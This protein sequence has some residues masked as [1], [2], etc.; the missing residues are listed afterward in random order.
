M[1]FWFYFLKLHQKHVLKHWLQTVTHFL[2]V[3]FSKYSFVICREQLKSYCNLVELLIHY[4]IFGLQTATTTGTYRTDK[5]TGAVLEGF[6]IDG[7]LRKL[8]FILILI[9]G[10]QRKLSFILILINGL[11]RKLSFILF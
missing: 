5:Y 7:V 8:F 11:Q 4:L 3:F 1:N 10:L 6:V 9:D 2:Q